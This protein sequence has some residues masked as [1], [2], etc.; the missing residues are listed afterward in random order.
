MGVEERKCLSLIAKQC[1]NLCNF[2][3]KGGFRLLC[4]DYKSDE[5]AS[6]LLI[7]YCVLLCLHESF[8]I[9]SI[10]LW[11]LYYTEEIAVA[12]RG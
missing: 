9:R 8:Y 12:V 5:N 4:R 11:T 1:D 10:S 7:V 6:V 3:N 2:T